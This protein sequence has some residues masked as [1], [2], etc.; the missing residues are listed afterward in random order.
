MV[1]VYSQVLSFSLPPGFKQGSSQVAGPSFISEWVPEN[2]TVDKWTRMIT[3]TGAQG[4]ASHANFSPKKLAEGRASR[5]KQHC[6]DSFATSAL[7]DGKISDHEAFIAVVLCGT[8]AL[9][10]GNTSES[11][12]IAE[13]KGDKDYYSL[14]RAERETAT[15]A[16]MAIDVGSR[17]AK[18]KRLEPIRFCPVVPG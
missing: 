4:F 6:P 9:P 10:A 12:V 5:Y 14:Q 17:L 3:L 2:E 15:N 13:I 18:F 1:P 7:F 16:P 11:A 8:V